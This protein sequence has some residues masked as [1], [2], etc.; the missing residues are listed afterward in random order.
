MAICGSFLARP[1]QSLIFFVA[2]L[3]TLSLFYY[4]N[5]Q[6]EVVKLPPLPSL[7]KLPDWPTPSFSSP[8]GEKPKPA[9]EPPPACPIDT[10]QRTNWTKSLPSATKSHPIDELIRRG[11]AE[12]QKLL[13]KEVT[14]LGSA[15]EAYRARRGRHPPPRFDQWVRW[16]QT[17]DVILI[18]DLFDQIYHDL[19]PFWALQAKEIREAA[20]S[21]DYVLSIRNGNLT[22]E[23]GRYRMFLWHDMLK[24]LTGL[25]PDVDLAWNIMD[26]SRVVVAHEKI[27]EYMKTAAG[28]GRIAQH[29]TPHVSEFALLPPYEQRSTLR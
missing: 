2:F 16:A 23:D 22:K 5:Q 26:E 7:P 1:R 25:L 17:H 14:D 10:A 8:F 12:F 27:S 20:A 9:P 11:E 4:G 19:E 3:L 13:A 24:Q 6:V 29:S 28:R 15:A 21:N 18:E